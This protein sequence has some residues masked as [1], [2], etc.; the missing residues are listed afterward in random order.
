MEKK[1]SEK[2]SLEL[3]T[4]MINN[5]KRNLNHGD[6]NPLIIWGISTIIAS[7]AVWAAFELSGN[8]WS[9]WLWFLI[10]VIGIIWSRLAMGVKEKGV[11]TQI[12]KTIRGISSIIG[13]ACGAVPLVITFLVEVHG[14]QIPMENP[15]VLYMVIPFVEILLVSI[16][17]TA[18]G[19]ITEFKPLKIGGLCGVA[20]SF[21][22]FV[23]FPFLIQ[24]FMVWALVAMVIPGIKLNLHVK[25]L[26]Q[27]Q[28][29]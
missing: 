14:D 6:G 4:Q 23:A 22:T 28:K 11:K 3:I 20:I 13:I 5:T 1:F 12:D 7:V 15:R 8:Y 21:C 18:M 24:I 10:P 27:C 9:M 19:V 26:R 25:K 2:E 29:N 16:Q 17:M